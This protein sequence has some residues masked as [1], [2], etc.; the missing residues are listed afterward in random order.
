MEGRGGMGTMMSHEVDLVV[1]RFD[2]SQQR[3]KLAIDHPQRS[4]RGRPDGGAPR[5]IAL[6]VGNDSIDLEE[7]IFVKRNC[8]QGF[9]PRQKAPAILDGGMRELPIALL[10][11]EPFF[12]GRRDNFAAP[13][14][15]GRGIVEERRDAKYV[16]VLRHYRDCKS[17]RIEQTRG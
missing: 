6:C 13:D 15:R 11:A 17:K 14:Q 9:I 16:W 5:I 3:G 7:W 1:L 8:R 4:Q 2:R 10:A 12:L